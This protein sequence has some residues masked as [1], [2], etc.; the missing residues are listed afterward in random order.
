MQSVISRRQLPPPGIPLCR[1]SMFQRNAPGS[2]HQTSR[3]ALQDP[4]YSSGDK[5]VETFKISNKTCDG[6]GTEYKIGYTVQDGVVTI[7]TAG[8]LDGSVLYFQISQNKVIHVEV[9]RFMYSSIKKCHG[10][11]FEVSGLYNDLFVD[12]A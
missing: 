1:R 4:S 11:F 12:T 9:L 6:C 5:A 7:G 8:L 3:K 10:S 2:G